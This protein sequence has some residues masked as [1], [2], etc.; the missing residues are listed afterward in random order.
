MYNVVG[1]KLQFLMGEQEYTVAVMHIIVF[2]GLFLP[3]VRLLYVPSR[4]YSTILRRSV[5]ESC[6]NGSF[7][8]LTCIYKEENVPG[9]IHILEV[10][11]P[12][13]SNPLSVIALQLMQLTGRAALPFM[14]PLDQVTSSSAFRSNL[15]R[16]NR[17]VTSFLH[18]ERENKGNAFIQHYVA[19]SPYA[20]MHNDIC[21][22]AY[23]KGVNIIIVPF[24]AHWDADGNIV[25]PSL[26]IRE[27]NN[28]V[29]EK[30]PCSVGLLVDRGLVAGSKSRSHS[31][32][33]LH[34]QPQLRID[35]A[36]N[37][38]RI[39][40]LFA[41]GSDDHEA[42]A[43]SRLL[44]THPRVR[45]VVVWLK[46][47]QDNDIKGLDHDVMMQFRQKCLGNVRMSFREAVVND[48]AEMT[49]VVVSIK[50]AVDLVLVGKH[51]D[52]KCPAVYGLCDG[53][54]EYP[55]LG[56]IG[57][58]LASSEFGFSI[59]VVQHEQRSNSSEM[60]IFDM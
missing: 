9:L 13:R 26:P 51:H 48:G 39:A 58:M 11:H 60:D 47:P 33:Q 28:K 24:H 52:P 34:P 17:V 53:L 37:V 25:D 30:A 5:I 19:V 38:Y 7:H 14:G 56:V 44:A 54:I 29:L 3:L 23:D 27:V 49:Q 4:Q 43:Y 6:E 35:N 46:G 55:E 18:F 2:A 41:G 16:C 21:Q 42:L 59:L 57:D 10:N 36:D 12:T 45:V 20:T 32:S 15:A 31:Q 40:V 1:I 22:L 50:D 8:A